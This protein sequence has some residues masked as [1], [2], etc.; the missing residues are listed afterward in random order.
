LLENSENWRL[1]EREAP[2][3]KGSMID[4]DDDDSDDY[5][6]RNTHKTEG[7][8]RAKENLR[9]HAEGASIGSKV[10]EMVK[11]KE[12]LVEKT[13][14]TKLL[15]AEKKIQEKQM[16]WQAIREDDMRKAAV[17]EKRAAAED[18]RA[19]AELITED[20]KIMMMDPS[21][22]DPFTRDWW[23]LARF[24]ILQ[25][26]RQ[27]TFGGGRFG[28]SGG[29]GRGGGGAADGVDGGH[30]TGGFGDDPAAG[31]NAGDASAVFD[32]EP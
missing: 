2:P 21:T 1:R 13:L 32:L 9:R 18:K 20:N 11:S 8:K 22:M 29:G 4:L 31:A 6:R 26:R 16:R 17:E 30:A 25:R 3:K 5:E 27:E 15:I 14:E 19:M 24:Y 10:E 7:C 23:D 28:G 12:K